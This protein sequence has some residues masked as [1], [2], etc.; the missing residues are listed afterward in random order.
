M[1]FGMAMLIAG[2][3][4]YLAIVIL[5]KEMIIKAMKTI[6]DRIVIGM[7]IS[8]VWSKAYFR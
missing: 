4:P 7:N 2:I 3:I 8:L 6:L 1:T 5:S